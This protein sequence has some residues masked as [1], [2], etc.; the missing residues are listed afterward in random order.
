MKALVDRFWSKVARIDGDGC[1]MWTAS[2]D[3]D[4]YGQ[5]SRGSH[6]DGN[7]KAHRLSWELHNGPIPD[8]LGV[9]HRC[10]TPACV[11]PDHLFLG[12]QAENMRDMDRKGRRGSFDSAGASNPNARLTSEQVAEIRAQSRAGVSRSELARRFGVGTS[13][14]SR[15][16]LGQ[17]WKGAPCRPS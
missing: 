6:G 13:T 9:L 7:V 17:A 8:G 1:W 14:V 16:A 11:R 2:V 3:S 15:I 12:T 10:D 4:G 5:L